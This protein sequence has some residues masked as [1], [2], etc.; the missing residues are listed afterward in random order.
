[1]KKHYVEA[2]L[3]EYGGFVSAQQV[4]DALRRQDV[5][6]SLPTVYR[7]LQG[8]DNA[9]EVDVVQTNAHESVYRRCTPGHHHHL[10]CTRCSSATEVSG[11]PLESWITRVS[12]TNNFQ[13]SDHK[14]EI[15]GLCA[16]CR[17]TS[18]KHD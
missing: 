18:T 16:N 3:A 17:Q 4:Y 12:R 7:T 8:M 14:V 5:S 10:I 6:I 15:Y 11:Q 1:V 9:G 2:V 13:V